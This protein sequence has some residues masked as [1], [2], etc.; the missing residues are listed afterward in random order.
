MV[1][2]QCIINNEHIQKRNCLNAFIFEYLGLFLMSVNGAGG[3][4]GVFFFFGASAC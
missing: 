4:F 3:F 2:K 1:I